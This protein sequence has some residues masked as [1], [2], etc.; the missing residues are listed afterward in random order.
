MRIA[1]NSEIPIEWPA[2]LDAVEACHY[3]R[4]LGYDTRSSST[5]EALAPSGSR[6][7]GWQSM[8]IDRIIR[9]RLPLRTA[10]NSS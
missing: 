3:G 9:R 6:R 5:E 7:P 10:V 4:D 1:I 8:S 2:I